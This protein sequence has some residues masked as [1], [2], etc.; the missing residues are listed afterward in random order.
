MNH[1]RIA[2]TKPVQ[3]PATNPT[4]PSLMPI[5]DHPSEIMRG[6]NLEKIEELNTRLTRL[7][8]MENAR[9]ISAICHEIIRAKNE[10]IKISRRTGYIA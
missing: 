9:E 8:L 7:N 6:Y 5:T 4:R 3:L 1:N 2:V 10:L